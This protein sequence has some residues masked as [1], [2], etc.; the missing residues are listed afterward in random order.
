MQRLDQIG[1]E[2]PLA[3]LDESFDRHAGRQLDVTEALDFIRGHRN[4]DQI[5]ALA[6]PLIGRGIRPN[7]RDGAVEFGG[8]TLVKCRETQHDRLAERDQ[9]DVLGF[10][11]DLDRQVVRRRR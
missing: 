4:A 2:R 7:A 11:L 5:I 6:G 10:D 9:V 8:R 1:H 3:G